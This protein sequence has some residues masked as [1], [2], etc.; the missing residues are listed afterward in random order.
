MDLSNL[1]NS[2]GG[3]QGQVDPARLTAGVREVFESKGG[4]HG[5]LATLRAGGLG[6]AVDSW[7][8]TGSNEPVE[9]QKLGAAL[10]PDTVNQLSTKTGISIESLLPLLA[11]FLPM[12]IDH[13]TPDGQVPQGGQAG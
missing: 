8:S 5:L 3:G 10:G 6:G 1:I 2:I 13:L 7:I 11:A 9:P 12:I 4:V